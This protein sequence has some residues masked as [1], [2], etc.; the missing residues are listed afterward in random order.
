MGK[1]LFYQWNAFMQRGIENALK[2]LHIDYD[3]YYDIPKNW[4]KDV[5]F[6]NRFIKKIEKENYSKILSVNFLPLISDIC[7]NKNIKYISWVYDSPLHIRRKNTLKNACNTIYFFDRV[8]ADTYRQEGVEGARYLPL[9]SSPK[10]F[11]IGETM[12]DNKEYTS[13]VAFLGQLYKSEFYD[14][15]GGLSQYN[16]GYLE[17]VMDA[18]IVMP[19]GYLVDEMLD[20]DVMGSINKDFLKKSNGTYMV[21]KEELSYT[22]AKEITGRLRVTALSVLQNRFDVDVYSGD[23]SEQLNN[24]NYKGYADYYDRMPEV[25]TRSKIN[26]NISLCTIQSGIPLRV[27]DIMA[28]RGFVISNA[29]PELYE[30]FVPGQ[31]I[32]IY[33]DIPDLVYK[34]KYYLEHEEQRKQIAENGYKKVCTEFNFEHRVKTM[35][36]I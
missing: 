25:F 11:G 14:I 32:E 5:A 18:Q 28:C 23:R 20:S 17:A 24:V 34:V 12:S 8:Q 19:Q 1:I 13:D 16:R 26:L 3:T 30:Y 22:L 15:A 35:L 31:D 9:A 33:E 10:V 27:I 21:T 29:Q 4:D 2:A 6:S 7:E 36:E